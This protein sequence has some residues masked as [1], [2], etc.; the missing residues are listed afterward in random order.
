MRNLSEWLDNFTNEMLHSFPDN[1]C[2][3]GLQ[4]SYGRGEASADSDLDL[5]VIFK[6]FSLEVLQQYKSLLLRLGNDYKL[7]GFVGSAEILKSWNEGEL[8]Q[9]YFDTVPVYGNLDFIKDRVTDEAAAK[10]VLQNSCLIY[11]ACCHNFLFDE[12][13]A[14]LKELYKTAVFTVQAKYYHAHHVYVSK[15]SELSNVAIGA[16]KEIL[17]MAVKLKMEDRLTAEQ[18]TAYSNLLLQWSSNNIIA[19]GKK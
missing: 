1:I 2:C 8:L 9:L 6:S 3:I 7:C 17:E 11:H 19:Y 15:H 16:D 18:L 13:Q 14:I 5:V 10:L 4:G 12:V